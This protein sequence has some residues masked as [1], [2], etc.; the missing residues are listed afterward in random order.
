MVD[1]EDG[2]KCHHA[3]RDRNNVGWLGSVIEAKTKESNRVGM[4]SSV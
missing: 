4:L 2:A 3:K 1:I